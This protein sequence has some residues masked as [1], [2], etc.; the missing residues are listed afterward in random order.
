MIKEGYKQVAVVPAGYMVVLTYIG[1][2]IYFVSNSSGSFWD[3]IVGLLQ[4][5]V[6][7]AYVIYGLL[8]VLGA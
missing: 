8:G 2:A 1:A 5:L 4:A 7:P 3:V 6:W